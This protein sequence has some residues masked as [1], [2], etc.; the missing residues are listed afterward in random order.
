M[1]RTMS[2]LKLAR[3]DLPHDVE[4]ISDRMLVLIR[5]EHTDDYFALLHSITAPGEGP[6]MHLHHREDETYHILDGEYE[7]RVADTTILAGR[8]D[9]VYGPRSIPHTYRNIG[10]HPA[11]MLVLL[12]PGGFERF[13]ER[14]GELARAGITDPQ[15]L[16]QAAAQFG[17]DILGPG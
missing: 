13:F 3:S 15:S 4:V 9:T 12:T 6:P 10:K 11:K 2:G 8:G 7:F 5:G 1:L 17:C 14:V 16:T